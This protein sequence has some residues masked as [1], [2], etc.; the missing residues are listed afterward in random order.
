MKGK[1]HMT[2]IVKEQ[3]LNFTASILKCETI[4]YS[5]DRDNV[6]RDASNIALEFKVNI[7]RIFVVGTIASRS[8]LVELDSNYFLLISLNKD[9]NY[10]LNKFW[11]LKNETTETLNS[12]SFL[13]YLDEKK[14]NRLSFPKIKLIVLYHEETFPY[15]RFALG[16]SDICGSIRDFAVG[17]VSLSDMQSGKSTSDIMKEIIDEKPDIIGFSVT[18]GQQDILDE[19]LNSVSKIEFY[20]PL[21][22]VGGSLAFLNREPILS[23]YPK[24]IVSQGYGETTFREIIKYWHNDITKEQV[25]GISYLTS[26]GEI[27]NTRKKDEWE[28]YGLPELDLLPEILNNKGVMTL[29]CSRGCMNACTFCPR[30]SKGKW[31]NINLEHID[32]LI[33][34]IS[35]IFN[36]YP[37]LNR[38]IFLVDEEFF[39]D[40]NDVMIQNRILYIIKVFKKYNFNFETSARIKQVYNQKKDYIWHKHRFMLLDLLK[41]NGLS[42]CLFGVESGVDS[43]LKRYNKNTTSEENTKAIRVLTSLGI[44]FRATY[45]TFDPLMSMDELVET[46]LYQGRTDLILEETKL[47]IENLFDSISNSKYIKQYS[48]DIPLYNKIPYMLVS[49]ECLTNSKYLELAKKENLLLDFNMSMGKYNSIYKDERIGLMSYYSQ[50]WIDKNFALDYFFKSMMK[51]KLIET[52][53]YLEKFRQLFKKNSY[54]LLGMFLEFTLQRDDLLPS[55]VEKNIKVFIQH[56]KKG[57]SLDTTLK[58]ITLFLFKKLKTEIEGFSNE[59]FQY[60]EEDEKKLFL[61]LYQSWL[62]KNW[63]LINEK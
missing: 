31:K 3:L 30:E 9:I 58:E 7:L 21:V 45:I 15:P 40:G 37:H 20:K 6:V 60:L 62:S 39:G 14:I 59:L 41:K 34:Y 42:K 22:I 55:Y 53:S 2:T 46:Y 56:C 61:E 50:L 5:V 48:K 57:V 24:L 23:I 47:D 18:F 36:Q 63:R 32:E 51:I 29:E 4:K 43:I 28:Y 44:P 54:Y 1:R 27:K 12:H 8:I 17:Q 33:P 19:L 38:K 35:Y 26:E 11:F 16:I 49:L 10:I 25:S 13:V 52:S